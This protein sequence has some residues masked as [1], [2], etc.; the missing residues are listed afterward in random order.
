MDVNLNKVSIG[1]RTFLRDPQ[2][3]EVISAI[4]DTMP[5]T[6]IC[7]ADDGDKSEEKS[8]LYLELVKQ[9][10]QVLELPF[11]SGLGAKSNA[12]VES[13]S[14][15][16]FLLG[17][18]DFD[19]RPKEVREGIEKLVEVLDHT[20]VDVASGRVNNIPYEF[21]LEEKDGVVKEIPVMIDSL[22]W[23]TQVDLTV[24]YFLAKRR[25]FE[26]VRWD[27]PIPRIGGAEH[28]ALYHDIKEAG[29]KVA[30]VNGVNINTLKMVDTI[31]YRQFRNRARSPERP[32][33]VK[34]N[35]VKYV[36]GNGQVDF[37]Q[38][39]IAVSN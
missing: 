13:F 4:K 32:C 6:E 14:H 39:K 33:F 5:E 10:H 30:L 31:R 1:I 21:D 8:K 23:F 20:D 16:Y 15:P 18:D 22:T 38:T 2:L 17:T 34:R 37:D 27:A 25:V 26:K 35:V 19:F 7:I 11:D 9:G 3:F 28:F 12:L 36:M 24:N 29:F